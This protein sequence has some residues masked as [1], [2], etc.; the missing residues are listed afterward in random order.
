[1]YSITKDAAVRLYDDELFSTTPRRPP[2]TIV[3]A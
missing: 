3:S 1:M 2:A